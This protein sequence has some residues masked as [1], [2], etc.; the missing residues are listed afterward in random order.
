MLDTGS[1]GDDISSQWLKSPATDGQEDDRTVRPKG[2]TNERRR[3][4]ATTQHLHLIR[5]DFIQIFYVL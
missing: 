4:E 3:R 5:M 2:N 1:L